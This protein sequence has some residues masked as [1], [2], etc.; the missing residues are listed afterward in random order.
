MK[1]GFTQ[2]VLLKGG[3]AA[4]RADGSIRDY[5]FDRLMFP[6]RDAKG[7][8]VGFGGR[9]LG[10]G[11]PKYLNTA[12]TPVFNKSRVLYGL[13]EGL[14]ETRKAR[15]A[16]LM[17]GYMDVIASHQ[18]G[19]KTACAPLGTALTPEHAL[20]IKRY[21]DSVAIVFDADN[22]GQN[23]AVRGAEVALEAGLGTR[24]ASVL[25][26]KDP[27]E[28]LHAHGLEK[29]KESLEEAV[30][31]PAFKTELLIKRA[32]ELTPEAKSAIAKDVL[33]TIAR[34]PDEVLKDEWIRR[35]AARLGLNDDSLRRSSGKAVPQS[36]R[37]PANA[38]APA[39]APSA[40]VRAAAIPAGDLQLLGVLFK[41]PMSASEIEPSDLES[42]SAREIVGALKAIKIEDKTWGPRLL[43]ALQPAERAAAS[44]LLGDDLGYDDPAATLRTLV[45]KRRAQ[46]RLKELE[47]LVLSGAGTVD[48]GLR[49]EFQRLVAELKGTKR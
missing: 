46:K 2:D 7:G 38:A 20:L 32:G 37:R 5:F 15:K 31:L 6:I 33:G 28:Y 12:E 14:A 25:D 47:P 45:A 48:Q 30:D 49:D 43:D 35:L 26:G 39:P 23:A 11:E 19:L 8:F 21:A 1:K 27:D 22:A 18:H 42:A 4:K 40:P 16:H 24:V 44:R 29:F 34:C 13:Y 41:T 10:D 3:L 17:E 9:T 36:N